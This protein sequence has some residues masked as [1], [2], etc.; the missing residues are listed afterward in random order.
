MKK[1]KNKST[2]KKD[3][4]FYKYKPIEENNFFFIHFL[5]VLL[6]VLILFLYRLSYS[7]KN[8]TINIINKNELELNNINN[9]NEKK[10]QYFCCYCTMGREEN[11]YVK[12]L[13]EYYSNLGVEKFIIGDNNLINTEKFS[14]I[15]KDFINN[16]TV[17][18]IN[19]IG[20]SIS[21]ST[22]YGNVYDKY[23]SKCEWFTFF[24]FDE[25]LI[26]HF[27]KEKNLT[28]KEYI[29]NQIF[30]KCEAILFN[31]LIY[32]DNNLL[33]YDNR[34]LLE[35]FT[36]PDF[37]NINNMY[38]KSMIRGNINKVAFEPGKTHHHPNKELI[39][40]DSMGEKIDDPSETLHPP[41]FKYAYLMHFNT[42]TA[43]EFAKKIKKGNLDNHPNENIEGKIDL[44]FSINNFTKEKLEIFEKIFNQT[45]EKYHNKYI[46]KEN[47]R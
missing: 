28:I 15:L 21:Q 36:I 17:D 43:E 27:D 24:D 47:K 31:W 40:C 29:S 34:T 44:F 25:Y 19:I 30:N 38:V 35:R 11:I 22:F 14:D 45:F 6:L 18:I 39:I 8:N 26:M 46:Y 13:I 37:S 33:Y 41:R 32:T 7:R 9:K 16:G 42:K 20:N 3:D 2:K 23:K 10:F 4:I 12:E 5:K 1:R